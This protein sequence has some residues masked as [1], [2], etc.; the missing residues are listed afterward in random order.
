LLSFN[1]FHWV[2]LTERD[3][4]VTVQFWHSNGTN[5]QAWVHIR[6]TSYDSEIEHIHTSWRFKDVSLVISEC[7]SEF[8][9]D[10]TILGLQ[11][12]LNSVD[13]EFLVEIDLNLVECFLFDNPHSSVI[14]LFTLCPYSLP[15]WLST[16]WKEYI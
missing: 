3:R 9:L 16:S 7:D 4:E 11:I 15:N 13:E 12:D 5:I 8:S 2:S 14:F 1:H 6:L 10:S